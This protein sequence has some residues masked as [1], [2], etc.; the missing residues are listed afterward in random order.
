M[1]NESGVVIL[2]A[3]NSHSSLSGQCTVTV[4]SIHLTGESHTGADVARQVDRGVANA[5]TQLLQ[6]GHSVQHDDEAGPEAGIHVAV[7]DGV[8][9]TVGHC[10]P[11][12]GEPHVRQQIPGGVDVH[13]LRGGEGGNECYFGC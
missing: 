1:I 3:P 7:D 5:A 2:V 4:N 13:Y 10:E 6:P 8:V 11:V 9:A 12:E